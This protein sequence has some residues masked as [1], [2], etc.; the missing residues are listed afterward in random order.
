MHSAQLSARCPHYHFHV[1]TRLAPDTCG[2]FFHFPLHR[3]RLHPRGSCAPAAPAAPWTVPAVPR[4]QGMPGLRAAGP[5]CRRSLLSMNPP[6][7]TAW[8][9]W[10]GARAG[11]SGRWHSATLASAG[12]CLLL[13]LRTCAG[14]LVLGGSTCRPAGPGLEPGC[15]GPTLI[16][17]S[18]PAGEPGYAFGGRGCQ[19]LS[20]HH[21]A[22]PAASSAGQCG[23]L[24]RPSYIH[25]RLAGTSFL[26]RAGV[27]GSVYSVLATARPMRPRATALPFVSTHSTHVLTHNLPLPRLHLLAPAGPLG[28]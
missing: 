23:V 11:G 13:L 5:T 14:H 24:G 25:T 12:G 19:G 2:R 8:R 9:Q 20:L 17:P 28:R 22:P 15:R 18:Y 3:C 26:Q 16:G 6:T 10:A 7:R 4:G 1:R 21:A 27:W